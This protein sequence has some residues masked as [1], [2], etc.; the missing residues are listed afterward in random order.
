MKVTVS[1]KYQVVIP[2]K[3]RKEVGIHPGQT[4]V[5]KTD[6]KGNIV[7]R[8]DSGKQAIDQLLEKYGGIL[9]NADTEWKKQGLDAAVW[10]RKM[11]DEEWD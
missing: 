7:L 2:K 11:R 10:L 4:I 6:D 3:V 1:S 5:V 9:A 8:K